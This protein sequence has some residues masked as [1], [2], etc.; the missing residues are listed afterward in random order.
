MYEKA[1]SEGR[2]YMNCLYQ[3]WSERYPNLP[4]S[5]QHLRDQAN[6]LAKNSAFWE[7]YSITAGANV[8]AIDSTV[9]S[10]RSPAGTADTEVEG[11]ENSPQATNLETVHTLIAASQSNPPLYQERQQLTDPLAVRFWEL[12]PGILT[13][14]L[15]SKRTLPRPNCVIQP[16]SLQLLDDCILD[17]LTDSSD[18]WTLNCCVYTAAF[19]LLE[20]RGRLKPHRPDERKETQKDELSMVRSDLASV[21][22]ELF[23]LKKNLRSRIKKEE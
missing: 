21:S 2:G 14:N 22:N 8:L 11:V 3:Y 13:T 19:V 18:L 16:E 10:P 6:R 5:H 12:L 17:S 9:I 4:F 7:Q 15:T 20:S 1:R 23:R